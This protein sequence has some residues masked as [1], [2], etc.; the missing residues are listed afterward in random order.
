[1]V[2]TA[3]KGTAV[4]AIVARLVGA[5]ARVGAHLSPHV[6]DLRER[7]LLDGQLPSWDRVDQAMVGLW[8]A[9][10]GVEADEGRPPSFFELTTALA[11]TIGRAAGADHLVT[12]AG[13]GG[14][15]DATNTIER[16][17]K[18]TVVMP[19]GYDH[20]EI[21]GEDLHSIAADKAAVI[22]DGGRVIMAPQRYP[23]AEA[24]VRAMAAERG[25]EIITLEPVAD[26]SE[27][28]ERVATVVVEILDD[29]L[30]ADRRASVHLPGRMEEHD[31]DGRTVILDGAHN[32]MKL[33][34]V[35]QALED[36]PAVL[37]AALSHEKDLEA[38][39]AELV[40]IAAVI[41][42][43]DFAV[44]AGDRVVRRSWSSVDLARALKAARPT[45]EVHVVPEVEAAVECAIA[46]TAPGDIV[47]A[48]GSFMILDPVRSA[49]R[50]LD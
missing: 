41:V 11:W 23:E 20:L 4:G 24:V 17:D 16:A 21:L 37:V 48:T 50:A 7:F 36:T 42:A 9:L 49:A 35:Q 31:V 5:G 12:E 43:S 27:Q 15:Y 39:A 8:P 26:W 45:V 2:G 1:M 3:G 44:K 38:C 30:A 32:P 25:A 19:I 29:G 46:L 34:G 33:R 13:I 22:P 6:Y 40:E 10:T 28:A 47:L 14:R 18:I